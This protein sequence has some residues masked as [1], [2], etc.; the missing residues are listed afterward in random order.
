MDDTNYLKSLP[1]HVFQ[2]WPSGDYIKIG[3]DNTLVRFI[4]Y[5][6]TFTPYELQSL[7]KFKIYTSQKNP[8]LI[9]PPFYSDPELIR[10]LIG[11]KFNMQK[12]YDALQSS[13]S[14]RLGRLQNS[15]RSLFPECSH[16]LNSGSIYFH[17]RDKRFRPLLIINLDKINFKENS[18]DSYCTLLC[19]LLEFAVQRL[20]IP[21]Q[22]ENWLIITD[23]CNKSLMSLPISDMQ[24]IIKVLQDN[25]RCRMIANFVLNSPRTV[26]YVWGL[27]KRFL[28]EHTIRKIRIERTGQPLDLFSFFNKSQLEEKYG[29]TAPNLEVFWPPVFPEGPYE[30]E[31]DDLDMYLTDK[32]CY[33]QIISDI[34]DISSNMG[35]ISEQYDGSLRQIKT[36]VEDFSLTNFDFKLKDKEEIG[37]NECEC[38]NEKSEEEKESCQ[39]S[40]PKIKSFGSNIVTMSTEK[41]DK[42][43]E[44]TSSCKECCKKCCNIY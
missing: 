38:L 11:C 25:F 33:S 3:K 43:A 44:K 19:F 27:A 31:G 30:V 6:V 24:R 14:W 40:K 37:I 42:R 20:M 9:L 16:L 29:G 7:E 5:K 17:G 12:A 1:K 34:S 4:F 28:E 13:I 15:F 36:G 32:N 10:I 26:Y 8:T 22:I 39:E 2:Y 41:L 35:S 18:V 23:L 21:G